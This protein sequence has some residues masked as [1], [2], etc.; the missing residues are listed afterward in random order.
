[1]REAHFINI[2]L[3]LKKIRDQLGWTMDIMNK[4]TG[5]S[6]SYLS[7]F[8]RGVKLP[9]AKYLKYLHDT[10]HVNLD[11]IFGSDNRMLNPLGEKNPKPDF[12]KHSEEINDLLSFLSRVPHA[13]YAILAFFAE[14]KINN[15]QLIKQYLLD[16]EEEGK[17]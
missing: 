16:K 6:R 9:T 8:E 13:L 2:G 3:Q 7:D 14:Y 17:A 5:I 15:K 11:F 10:H 1:M 12:G 4:A